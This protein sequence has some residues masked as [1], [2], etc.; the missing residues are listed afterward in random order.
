MED[1]KKERAF[2]Y[3]VTNVETG[4]LRVAR[5]QSEAAKAFRAASALCTVH[6]EP[7]LS[8]RVIAQQIGHSH[9]RGGMGKD[10]MVLPKRDDPAAMRSRVCGAC[11]F[12]QPDTKT[13]GWCNYSRKERP[14][15]N[16]TRDGCK[17]YAEKSTH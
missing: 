12:F 3:V 16:H 9:F 4:E 5:T 8:G 10:N 11:F 7:L 15:V 17:H 1:E 13:F 6:K 14:L 2:V